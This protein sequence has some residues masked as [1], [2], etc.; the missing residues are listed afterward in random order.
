MG[1]NVFHSQ[2]RSWGSFQILSLQK[3]LPLVI[4]LL[5][6]GVVIFFSLV[7]YLSIRKLVLQD[8]KQRLSGLTLQVADMLSESIHDDFKST[9]RLFAGS[10]L[11]AFIKS[12]DERAK[13]ALLIVDK[14]AKEVL[15]YLPKYLIQIII[16]CY[17]RRSAYL[18]LNVITTMITIIY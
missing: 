5:L 10:S 12:G 9:G 7:S 18:P 17:R 4:S 6:I 8:N 3:G 13:R 11:P 16:P 15:L 2:K 1:L 14:L